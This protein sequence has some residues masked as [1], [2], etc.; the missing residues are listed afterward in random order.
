MLDNADLPDET[1]NPRSPRELLPESFTIL[2][3]DHDEFCRLARDVIRQV[4]VGVTTTQRAG[5]YGSGLG[6]SIRER[7]IEGLICKED[8]ATR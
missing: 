3:F 4:N 2:E 7:E 8:G 1:G 5:R 6:R